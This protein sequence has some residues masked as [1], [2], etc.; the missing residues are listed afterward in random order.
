MESSKCQLFV[1]GALVTS[2]RLKSRK[3]ADILQTVLRGFV[4]K[5]K[6][7]LQLLTAGKCQVLV[8]AQIWSHNNTITLLNKQFFLLLNKQS[9]FVVV[10]TKNVLWGFLVT[11]QTNEFSA[12]GRGERTG[13]GRAIGNLMPLMPD[14]SVARFSA[15]ICS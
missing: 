1:S 13:T 4:S 15:A 6:I 7:G 9:V 3:V 12:T 8:V 10:A 11:Q 14:S 2:S 5:R